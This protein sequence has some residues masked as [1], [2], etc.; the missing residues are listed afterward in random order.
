MIVPQLK[1]V[2]IGLSITSAWGNGHATTY[3]GL[4]RELRKQ[5]HQILFLERD[6][7]WY[8][9]NRD[10][11]NPSFCKTVIYNS[12]EELEDFNVNE[13]A[14]ADLVIIGSYVP[15]GVQVARWVL[16]IA[17]GKVAF[18]DIDTP[19]TLAKLKRGDNEYLTPELIHEFDL[20]L[21][22]TG[23]PTLVTLEKVYGSPVARALY[24]S[25]DPEKYFYEETPV[26][27]DMGYLGTYS[28]DRQP[29]LE[30][31][32]LKPARLQPEKTFIVAGPMYPE[33]IQWPYNIK[34]V[35]H[36][37]PDQHRSFY[38][39]QKYTLNVTRSDMIEA[40]YS[41]SVRLFEAAACRTPIISDFWEGLDSIFKIGEEI[42]VAGSSRDTIKF[43]SEIKEHQR[44]EIGRKAM[45]KVLAEHTATHR[46]QQLIKYFL[47]LDFNNNIRINSDRENT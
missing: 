44:I 42:L 27:Y 3:R 47:D 21:S 4:L 36:L 14:E 17:K 2:V 18:Y 9:S 45:L 22:F 7:E 11:P 29:A 24:C 35:Y 10:L 8:A 13:I 16:S 34:R 32:M 5:G 31:L 15:Q 30:E 1:I 38:N 37:N 25:V 40:G 39:S 46:A 41:P 12:I 19:V 33:S 28:D 23:G 43:L 20:Y 6:L 26:E